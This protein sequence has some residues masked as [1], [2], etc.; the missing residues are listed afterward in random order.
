MLARAGTLVRPQALVA[1]RR[2]LAVQST[3]WAHFA[4][5]SRQKERPVSPH[6]TIYAFPIAAISS[7]TTRL[8]GGIL[9]I[10]VYGIGVGALL[11]ADMPG[12]MASLGSSSIGSLVKFGVSFPL[13]YHFFAGLR[14][15][16][17][18]KNPDG[19]NTETQNNFTYGIF[20]ISG[21]ASVGA[22]LL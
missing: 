4:S 10:G 14:H 18:E 9:T 13:V 12:V 1:A 15:F 3:Q 19:L 17:W 22:M 20:T 5:D 11:G 6:V 16:Y 2:P 8:T 7:I 21:L